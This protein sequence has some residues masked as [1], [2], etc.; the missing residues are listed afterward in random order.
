MRLT[1]LLLLVAG[2]VLLLR[3]ISWA[4]DGRP[5]PKKAAEVIRDACGI[6]TVDEDAPGKPVKWVVFQGAKANEVDKALEHLRAF[7]TLEGL[8]VWECNITDRGLKHLRG[9]DNLHYLVLWGNP[10]TDKGL[11]RLKGLTG[12]QH[13]C[14]RDTK[15]TDKGLQSLKGL[16]ALRRL[17]LDRTKVTAAGVRDLQKALPQLQVIR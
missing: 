16:T 5:N 1:I 13:L 12:L 15:V 6:I 4:E 14:L 8:D 3:P 7:P 17:E 10:I 9:L 2:S 11:A